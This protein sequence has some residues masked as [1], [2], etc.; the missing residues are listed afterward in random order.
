[1][2]DAANLVLPPV[3]DANKEEGI[4]AKDEKVPV[5]SQ[6]AAYAEFITRNKF[7]HSDATAAAYQVHED[8][9]LIRRWTQLSITITKSKSYTITGFAPPT[10]DAVYGGARRRVVRVFHARDKVA[11]AQLHA[12]GTCTYEY[13]GYK[14]ERCITLAIVD[15]D[16]T[17]AYYRVFT[18]FA[19]IT[20]PQWKSK[21]EKEEA[22]VP[23]EEIDSEDDGDDDVSDA[24]AVAAS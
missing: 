6:L 15:D 8:L 4:D 13:E 5:P 9:R 18:Q 10:L 23:D 7:V 1:M 11:V 22:H 20:H 21:K 19:E 24:H 2:E 12:L 14:G 3:M 16:S 17:T